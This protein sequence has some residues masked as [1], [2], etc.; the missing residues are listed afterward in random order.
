MIRKSTWCKGLQ[1]AAGCWEGC[2]TAWW[3]D[4]CECC[5]ERDY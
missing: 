1:R 4:T 2:D 5:F 3:K